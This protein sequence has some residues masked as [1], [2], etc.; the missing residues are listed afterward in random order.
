MI[1]MKMKDNPAT[2]QAPPVNYVATTKKINHIK[3]LG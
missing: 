2:L 1:A 3:P